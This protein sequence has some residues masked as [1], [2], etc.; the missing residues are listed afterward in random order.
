MGLF[1]KYQP[2]ISQSTLLNEINANY[3]ATQAY[4]QQRQ[5]LFQRILQKQAGMVLESF[6]EQ[7][8]EKIETVWE[9]EIYNVLEKIYFDKSKTTQQKIAEVNTIFATDQFLPDYIEAIKKS[10][11]YLFKGKMGFTFEKFIKEQIFEPYVD[12]ASTFA[13]GHLE[14]LVSGAMTSLS[15]M[16]K[17]IKNVRS[18]LLISVSGISFDNDEKGVLYGKGKSGQLP[19]ELQR[20]LKINWDNA[21]PAFDN[22]IDSSDA[23]IINNFLSNEDFFG[24]SAKVYGADQD[25]KHFSQST[26]VQ[27]LLNQVFWYPYSSNGGSAKRHSWEIDYAETYV[28][29]NLSRILRT[30]ISPTTIAMVYGDK[31]MWMSNFLQSKI[32]YMN[33]QYQTQIN[34]HYAG[35]GRIFPTINSPNIYTKN[36]NISKGLSA[37]TTKIVNK[38][39]FF[40]NTKYQGIELVLT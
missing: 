21:F 1:E 13:N 24:F 22:E 7:I 23:G 25:N 15:S 11:Y 16:T 5:K 29:W 2:Q 3:A 27:G 17:G 39:N 28:I 37:L 33:I 6:E 26:T 4:Y 34:K 20:E 12:I 14:S 19:L 10:N 8:N 40:N 35:D 32:F 38:T 9:K 31:F 18:D 30:I 36:Y